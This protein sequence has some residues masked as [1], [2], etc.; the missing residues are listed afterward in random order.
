MRSIAINGAVRYFEEEGAGPTVVLVHGSASSSRQWRKLSERLRD[1]YRVLAADL[2][3]ADD[4]SGLEAFTFAADCDLVVRLIG[5]AGGLA[6]LVG[7]SYGG[8]IATK[9]ALNHRQALASLTLIEPSCFHLLDEA[10]LSREFAEI[11]QVRERQQ[12]ALSSGEVEDS[13]RGFIDYWMGEGAW[14]AMPERRQQMIVGTLPKFRHDW[15]GTNHP[16]TRLA[17]YQSLTVRTLLIRAKDTVR[18]SFRIVDLL[19]ER[20]PNCML[21]EIAQGGHMS[22]LTNPDAVNAAIEEFL[23]GLSRK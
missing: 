10:E 2:S 21:T 7:H 22:P 20:L 23:D 1:R 19:A 6:H 5:D 17:D 4:G 8:V 9:V 13:A 15:H 14:A 3:T 12:R 11:L 18:P 16:V